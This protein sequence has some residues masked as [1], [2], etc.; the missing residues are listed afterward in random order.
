MINGDI[1][2]MTYDTGFLNP[3]GKFPLFHCGSLDSMP[4]CKSGLFSNEI[5]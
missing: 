2:M 3:F 4:T 5:Y 1:R